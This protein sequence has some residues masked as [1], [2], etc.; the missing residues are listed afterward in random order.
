MKQVVTE[1]IKTDGKKIIKLSNVAIYS[2]PSVSVLHP[3]SAHQGNIILLIKN[4][5]NDESVLTVKWWKGE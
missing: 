1:Q 4:I 5:K 3:S 2:L